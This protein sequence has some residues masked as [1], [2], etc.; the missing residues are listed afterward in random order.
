MF[1]YL[2]KLYFITKFFWIILIFF[3]MLI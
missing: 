2:M 1:N 3:L